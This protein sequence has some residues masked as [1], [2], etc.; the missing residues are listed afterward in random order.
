MTA[1]LRAA[2]TSGSTLSNAP[3]AVRQASAT[4]LHDAAG[5]PGLHDSIG[6]RTV[7]RAQALATYNKLIDDSYLLLN[8]VILT[9]T[10]TP[11]AA[12]ALALERIAKSGELLQQENVL[13]VSDMAARR[14]P[15]A[16]QHEFTKLAGAR[17]TLY[18]QTLP[19]LDPSYRAMYQRDVSPAAYAALT[20]LENTVIGSQHPPFPPPVAPADWQ[21]AVQGVSLGLEHAGTQAASA[22]DQQAEHEARITDLRL[23]LSGGLGLLAVV[24]SIIVSLLA[25]RGLVRELSGLRRSALDLAD[26]RLP[27]M[28]D[29]LATGMNV[30]LATTTRWT[31]RSRPGRSARCG[32]P[33]PRCSGPRWTRPWA[34]PGCARASARCSAIW[35]GAASRCCTAS[36][37]CLTGWNAAPRTRRNSGTSSGSTT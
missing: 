14:F 32:T 1:A 16:D 18:N 27:R 19:E 4:L 15:L 30:K 31:S 35:P 25:G 26:H 20:A 17:T 33:S 13:L 3:P 24:I 11:I 5:L 12:Q 37:R 34:R 6:A 22:L 2:L 21:R 23:L 29:Q 7:S 9:E 8:Q 10:S 28:V 36:S